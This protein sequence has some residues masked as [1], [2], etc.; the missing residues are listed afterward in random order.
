MSLTSKESSGGKLPRVN[1]FT[2]QCMLLV[3]LPLVFLIL[4]K[5]II[6]LVP[7]EVT[8]EVVPLLW[9]ELTVLCS[10]ELWEVLNECESIKNQTLMQKTVLT[11]VLYLAVVMNFKTHKFNFLRELDSRA[12]IILYFDTLLQVIILNKTVEFFLFTGMFYSACF[13]SDFL[14]ISRP[15]AQS[16][17][18]DEEC[19]LLMEHDVLCFCK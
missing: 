7:L 2:D 9:L 18:F 11:L 13:S 10:W 19:Y 15:G 17:L 4:I 16:S 8:D 14:W 1:N 5:K 6:F 3:A 12:Q